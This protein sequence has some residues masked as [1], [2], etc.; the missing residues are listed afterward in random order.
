[1]IGTRI[2]TGFLAFGACLAIAAAP[3]A[4]QW[5]ATGIGVAEID[6]DETLLLL[7]G[8][9]AS[10]GGARGIAPLIGVQ[11]Y[12]LTFDAGTAR[13][14]VT[15]IRPYAGLRSGFDG[16]SLYGTVGY[17]FSSRDTPV[18]AF[19]E[20]R[21]EGVVLSGGLDVWGT[22]SPLGYQALASYNFGSE[23]YWTRGRVTRRLGE[24]GTTQKRIGAEV[25]FMG[26]EGYT[27]WQPGVLLELHREGGRIIGFGAGGKF[28]EGGNSA[29]YLKVET[30]L[31]LLRP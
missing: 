7:A 13:T 2:R 25:A 5:S 12:W 24:A 28:S 29:A 16:G 4:A 21:G 10:P 22:G 23:S 18:G 14:N 8:V 27:A 31:P 9:S 6:T 3:A 11:G 17:A 15:A 1:M 19:V 26:G 20:D 30:V